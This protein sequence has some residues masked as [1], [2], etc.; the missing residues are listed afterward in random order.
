MALQLQTARRRHIV[1]NADDFGAS[2]RINQAILQAFEKRLISSATIMA[3]M[4]AFEE[5][6]RLARQNDLQRGIGL[7]LN[8]TEGKPLTREIAECPP[9]VMQLV[10]G[11]HAEGYSR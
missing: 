7:Y 2:R 8:L 9:F 4:P 1:V 11:V 10:A 3:N 6:C 5:A